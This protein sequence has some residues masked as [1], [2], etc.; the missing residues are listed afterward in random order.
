[1]ALQHRGLVALETRPP[2]RDW[3]TASA[4]FLG[5]LHMA[6]GDLL[7]ADRLAAAYAN[8]LEPQLAIAKAIG[9][10]AEWRFVN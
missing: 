4:E 7:K 8:T 3:E 10:E 1:V 2:S 6:S 9:F 5:D